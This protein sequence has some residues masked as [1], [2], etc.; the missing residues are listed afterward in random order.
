MRCGRLLAAKPIH[1]DH[2]F[3]T[4]H[5]SMD[6]SNS[7]CDPENH[8]KIVQDHRQVLPLL[9]MTNTNDS[10]V[11]NVKVVMIDFAHTVPTGTNPSLDNG[12]IAGITNLLKYLHK[13]VTIIDKMTGEITDIVTQFK[14]V[15]S[16]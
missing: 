6:I 15:S 10:C 1:P 12:Y 13:S 2:H 8:I 3:L 9:S 5:E 16:M 11:S 14:L 7:R 4:L